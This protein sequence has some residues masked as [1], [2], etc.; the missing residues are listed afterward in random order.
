MKRDISEV[1]HL[2][3]SVKPILLKNNE[4]RIRNINTKRWFGYDRANE[5]L[6][7]IDRLINLPRKDRMPNLLIIG[8]TNNG[9]TEI[10]KRVL[11]KYPIDDNPKGDAKIIPVIMI[12]APTDADEGRFYSKILSALNVPFRDNARCSAKSTQIITVAEQ[13]KLKLL[14]V[15]EIHDIIAGNTYRQRIFR[16]ALR[17]LGTELKISVVASGIQE[18]LNAIKTDPQLSNRFTTMRLPKWDIISTEDPDDPFLKLLSSYEKTMPLWKPSYLTGETIAM[19]LLSMCEG[20]IG[21][22][23]NIITMAAEYAILKEV[24]QINLQVLN[25]INW[26]MPSKR[27]T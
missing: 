20:L 4:E 8:E 26:I 15:D 18:A 2:I 13:V 11:R 14:I 12:Q 3:E 17:Q 21:E 6:A 23:S 16:N 19:K 1:K 10:L 24:E 9:K 27:N 7:Q 5:I 25:E 22:L